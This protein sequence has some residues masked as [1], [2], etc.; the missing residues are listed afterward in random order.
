MIVTEG[1]VY[2]T[3]TGFHEGDGNVNVT[4]FA[5]NEV[6]SISTVVN[7]VTVSVQLK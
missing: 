1:Y 3:K 5:V 6:P 4:G 7:T 2:V